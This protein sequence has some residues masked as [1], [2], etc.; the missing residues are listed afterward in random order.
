MCSGNSSPMSVR[1]R[2]R[3]SLGALR[4]LVQRA[5]LAP[6]LPELSRDPWKFDGGQVG[7]LLDR[8]CPV[9]ELAALQARVERGGPQLAEL[10]RVACRGQLRGLGALLQ[11]RPA[12]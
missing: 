5:V 2:G 12:A 4:A 1:D 6:R 11:V 10:Q 8:V 7:Q 3:F 9:D